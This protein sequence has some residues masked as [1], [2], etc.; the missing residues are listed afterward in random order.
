MKTHGSPS[1]SALI[2]I[3]IMFL[4]GIPACLWLWPNVDDTAWSL[5]VQSAVYVYF[6]ACSL[7]IGLR[8]WSAAQLGLNRNGIAFSLICGAVLIVGRLFAIFCTNIPVAWQF[9]TPERLIGDVLFYLLL[10]GV[11]EELVFRGLM[12]RALEEWRG[13]RWAIWGTT[14]AFGLWHVGRGRAVFGFL[15]GFII[16]LI[17]AGIRWRAGGIIGLIVVHA[18]V[19]LSSVAIMPDVRISYLTTQVQVVN[20]LLAV[21]SEV[22]LVGLLICL[23]KAPLVRQTNV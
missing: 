1:Q 14:I 23:W 10:V 4:P 17:F 20:S 2:E 3:G 19:D 7:L 16:G 13:T 22:T 8:R 11:T 18:L 5:P 9:N 15:A 21:L 6:I 12:Y